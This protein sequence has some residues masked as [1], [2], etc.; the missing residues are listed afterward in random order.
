MS[1]PT[2]AQAINRT[3]AATLNRMKSGCENWRRRS[4]RPVAAEVS[5]SRRSSRWPVNLFVGLQSVSGTRASASSCAVPCSSD[6]CPSR[7]PRIRSAFDMTR[8][9]WSRLPV[10]GITAGC[11][12]IG[13]NIPGRVP[14]SVPKNSAGVTPTIVNGVPLTTSVR[15]IADGVAAEAPHPVAVT[16]DRH[17]MSQHR[18]VVVRSEQAA[19]RRT[20]SEQREVAAGDQLAVDRGLDTPVDADVERHA[21]VGAEAEGAGVI[22]H[23]LVLLV[24]ES[25]E[26]AGGAA[27]RQHEQLL[28]IGD[29]Q[30]LPHHRVDQREQ[31][32]GGADADGQRQHGGR[33]EDR[34]LAERP[35][36][37]AQVLSELLEA[38]P[39]PLGARV[40]GRQRQVAELAG[41]RHAGERREL[42]AHVAFGGA[43]APRQQVGQSLPDHDSLSPVGFITRATART[44]SAHSDRS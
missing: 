24:G 22:A 15:P 26:H 9:C 2:L 11:I 13:R 7:R 40:F 4:D 33:G 16:Q 37:V 32:G 44:K 38:R 27:L 31:R 21:G 29:G 17:R 14:T 6:T 39:S 41:R 8:G 28:G 43:P 19:E 34:T 35:T 3:S 20:H 12:I 10:S 30:Q 23:D 42:L 18:A 1:V 25:V 36:G 5:S